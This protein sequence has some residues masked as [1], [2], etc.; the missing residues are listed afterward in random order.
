MP[1]TGIPCDYICL[2]TIFNY[3]NNRYIN[4]SP[5]VAQF[6]WIQVSYNF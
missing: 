6:F 4:K 3:I 2:Q 5:F 1:K